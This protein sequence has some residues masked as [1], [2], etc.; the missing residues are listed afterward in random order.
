MMMMK[1][2][3][4]AKSMFGLVT[5]NENKAIDS[6]RK[7]TRMMTRARKSRKFKSHNL[8]LKLAN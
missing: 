4:A 8:E 2:R 7:N 3:M 5:I 6:P 1:V